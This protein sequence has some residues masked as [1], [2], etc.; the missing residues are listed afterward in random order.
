MFLPHLSLL[1]LLSL[2][3][4]LFFSLLSINHISLTSLSFK[5]LV[6]VVISLSLSLCI[7]LFFVSW[8]ILNGDKYTDMSVLQTP[9]L[10]AV[11][12]YLPTHTFLLFALVF[13]LLQSVF[14]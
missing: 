9:F 4:P 1:S 5:S 7:S 3:S 14:A 10:Y 6:F 11:S 13:F 12:P 2:V 8:N